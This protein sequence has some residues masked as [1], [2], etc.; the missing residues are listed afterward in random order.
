MARNY[1]FPF[2]DWI[3]IGL[4][5]ESL[6]SAVQIINSGEDLS[7]V[8]GKY[9]RNR[10]YINKLLREEV[11]KQFDDLK[12]PMLETIL[13]S[14][15]ARPM[16][17]GED[18]NVLISWNKHRFQSKDSGTGMEL[19]DILTHLTIP[20]STKKKGVD[21]IGRF[22]VGF[23]STFNYCISQ[24]NRV[25]VT[26]DT[27]T[28]KE[29]Y[30][31]DFYSTSR[32]IEGLRMRIRKHIFKNKAGT[33]VSIN[34][35][36]P[37][38]KD[39]G[40]YFAS[41][42]KD[43]PSPTACIYLG[44]NKINSD[45]GLEWY[46]TPV[47]FDLDDKKI[48]QKVGLLTARDD[49]ST[50]SIRLTSQG[51][52][53]RKF[54]SY[55]MREATIYLPSAVKV[56]E[57]RDEFKIDENY[58]K[59]VRG[60]FNS[61]GEYLKKEEKNEYLLE[62]M[63]GFIPS[64][65]AA[66]SVNSIKE[67]PSIE[68]LREVLFPGK[69]YIIDSYQH[70]RLTPFFGPIMK[71]SFVAETAA[72]SYWREIYGSGED[73]ISGNF[74]GERRITGKDLPEKISLDLNFCPNIL[75]LVDGLRQFDSVIF[76]KMNASGNSSFFIDKNNI[77]VNLTHPNVAGA[78]SEPKVY[79]L[80][81]DFYRT[82]ALFSQDQSASYYASVKT[83]PLESAENTLLENLS[84]VNQPN[85]LRRIAELETERKNIEELMRRVKNGP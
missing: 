51:V 18:Y 14:I 17:L 3:S 23:L 55:K 60:V 83:S 80:L 64:L 13:N 46:N 40:L 35:K 8:I 85:A 42:L 6:E 22:G 47:E 50:P 9:T 24:P 82:R 34:R 81:S 59:A 31:V 58:R 19:R 38:R 48:T 33:S 4:N 63:A 27:S 72:C 73:L 66:L 62:E 65:A 67:I 2:V 30:L 25:H 53:V 77:Y 43:I 54:D 70:K 76:G 15:D 37:N 20:F 16:N 49:R 41:H 79:G 78:F 61:L 68:S 7:D 21:E 32:D 56:V 74:R 44:K 12:R 10:G 39:L 5:K 71:T 52:L 11:F 84:R 29:G 75:P 36:I 57:G 45:G 69:K 1:D 26:V 28:G